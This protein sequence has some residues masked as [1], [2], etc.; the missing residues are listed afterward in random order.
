M[1]EERLGVRTIVEEMNA[2]RWRVAPGPPAYPI[3]R[4]KEK[5]YGRLPL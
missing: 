1:Y 2:P 5:W 4:L 3:S